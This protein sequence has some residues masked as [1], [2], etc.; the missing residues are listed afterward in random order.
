MKKQL[1]LNSDLQSTCTYIRWNGWLYKLIFLPACLET[2]GSPRF[3]IFKPSCP[4]ILFETNHK[5]CQTCSQN[6]QD[7]YGFGHDATHTG[8]GDLVTRRQVIHVPANELTTWRTGRSAHQN[9]LSIGTTVG[10]PQIYSCIAQGRKRLLR[11]RN[12]QLRRLRPGSPHK[13]SR[14]YGLTYN[15]GSSCLHMSQKY[16][17]RSRHSTYMKLFH[18]HAETPPAFLGWNG[19]NHALHFCCSHRKQFP[20]ILRNWY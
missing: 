3:C 15:P 13:N 17:C 19:Q 2:H 9:P 1:I 20:S 10:S 4:C 14:H 5:T 8:P 12:K 16:S 18:M 7:L 6:K 11:C